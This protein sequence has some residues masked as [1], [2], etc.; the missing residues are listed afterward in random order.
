MSA[1]DLAKVL[2][3]FVGRG[4]ITISETAADIYTST[5]GNAVQ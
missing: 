3:Y 2:V 4:I 5:R 1:E